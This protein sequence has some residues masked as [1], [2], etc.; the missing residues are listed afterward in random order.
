MRSFKLLVS[1]FK[2]SVNHMSNSLS[3]TSNH[4]IALSTLY[5]CNKTLLKG[6]GYKIYELADL[7]FDKEDFKDICEK[8]SKVW[9]KI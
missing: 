4:V 3:K 8:L 6:L 1:L 9:H 7:D 5:E 2:N